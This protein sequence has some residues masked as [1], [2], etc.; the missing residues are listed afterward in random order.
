MALFVLCCPFDISV[1]VGAFVIGLGQI[2]SFLSLLPNLT[3]YMY[4]IVQ[5]FHRTYAT[6]AACQQRTLTP[7]NTWSCRTLGLACV[8]KSRPISPELV[9]F[10]G[11]WVSNIPRY[12]SFT[13]IHCLY[14]AM[15]NPT[16]C[17]HRKPYFIPLTY[18]WLYPK[19][20]FSFHIIN[21]KKGSCLNCAIVVHSSRQG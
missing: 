15:L 3:F 13:F 16:S 18:P 5:G 10:P 1:G 9:L 7:P 12:F 19:K 14:I 11:F 4:L 6:G 21:S 17:H 8:L 20:F 2:S